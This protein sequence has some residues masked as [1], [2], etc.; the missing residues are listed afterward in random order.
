MVGNGVEAVGRRGRGGKYMATYKRKTDREDDNS[1]SMLQVATAST[2]LG[3]RGDSS[4]DALQKNRVSRQQ[5]ATTMQEV[6]QVGLERNRLN[7]N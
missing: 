2:A 7:V 6:Y 5:A 4:V 3:M 1:S